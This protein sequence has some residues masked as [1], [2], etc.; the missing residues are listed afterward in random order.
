M[1]RIAALLAFMASPVAAETVAHWEGYAGATGNPST[2]TIQ[3]TDEPGAVAEIIFRNEPWNDSSDNGKP[4]SVT[5]ADLTVE[6]QFHWRVSGVGAMGF[7]AITVTVPEG[8]LAV[9]DRL[10]LPESTTGRVLIYPLFMGM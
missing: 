10:A 6:V 5:L 1:I 7:D 2:C 9:P 4:Q 8:Y 3:P